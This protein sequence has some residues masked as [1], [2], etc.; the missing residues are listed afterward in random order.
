M[1]RKHI[2]FACL[3]LII[4]A[5]GCRSLNQSDGA[6]SSKTSDTDTKEGFDAE[7]SYGKA[8]IDEVKKTFG[9]PSWFWGKGVSDKKNAEAARKESLDDLFSEIKKVYDYSNIRSLFSA[10]YADDIDIFHIPKYTKYEVYSRILKSDAE[11]IISGEKM[12]AEKNIDAIVAA[13]SREE[14]TLS[15]ELDILTKAY[16]E[17]LISPYCSEKADALLS[18]IKK[19][20]KNI[21]LTPY[22]TELS[23]EYN[24]VFDFRISASSPKKGQDTGS[25]IIL[26]YDEKGAVFEKI[27]T[28][29]DGTYKG[30]LASKKS[31]RGNNRFTCRLSAENLDISL[32]ESITEI[33]EAEF[34]LDVEKI[35]VSLSLKISSDAYTDTASVLAK[36]FFTD[37]KLDLNIVPKN[38]EEKYHI[39]CEIFADDIEPNSYGIFISTMKALISVFKGDKMIYRVETGKYREGGNSKK[40][41]KNKSTIKLFA[42]LNKDPVFAEGIVNALYPG[43]L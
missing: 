36:D 14:L 15:E 19:T 26:I 28:E 8:D 10:E 43:V 42:A 34:E 35:S 31:P 25:L 38:S 41:A 4:L 1:K 17:A 20:I 32:Y 23:C 6:A 9:D 29:E 2:F 21:S 12:K 5:G 3:I 37:E 22:R 30:V 11:R 13:A 40:E 7:D 33:P 18:R 27:K 39:Q 16:R 24:D